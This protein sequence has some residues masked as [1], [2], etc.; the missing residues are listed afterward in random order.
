MTALPFIPLVFSVVLTQMNF[1]AHRGLTPTVMAQLILSGSRI[2]GACS[3]ELIS[4]KLTG[5][6]A[7]DS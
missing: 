4:L 2:L 5:Q 7:T 6:P 3:P 1:M